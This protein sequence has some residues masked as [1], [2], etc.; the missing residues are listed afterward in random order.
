MR[1]TYYSRGKVPHDNG[2]GQRDDISHAAGEVEKKEKIASE[3]H[4]E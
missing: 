2:Q 3:T 1:T 4:D